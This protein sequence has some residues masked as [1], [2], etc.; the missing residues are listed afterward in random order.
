MNRST[1][2]LFALLIVLGAIV[3]FLIPSSKEREVSDKTPQLTFTVDSASVVRLD[4]L[5]GAKTVTFEN[6]GGRWMITAPGRYLADA[7]SVIQA[8]K[9]LASFRIGSL[10]SSNPEK[11]KLFQV[12]SSGTKITVT[13]RSGKSSSI[14]IGKMGPSFS[15]VYCRAPASRDVYLGEGIDSWAVNKE[16]KEWRDKA[17]MLM[18]SESVKDIS[19]SAGGRQFDF[20]RDSTTWELGTSTVETSVMNPPLATFAN[21]RADDF[22][23]TAVTPQTQPIA[24]TVKGVDRVTLQLFPVTPDSSKYVVRSS[25]SQQL[26]VINKYVAQQIFKPLEGQEVFHKGASAPMAVKKPEP[27]AT[28]PATTASGLNQKPSLPQAGTGEKK[29]TGKTAVAP[30]LSFGKKS[31]VTSQPKSGVTGKSSGINPSQ[32]IITEK[33]RTTAP[34]KIPNTAGAPTKQSAP[35]TNP[36]PMSGKNVDSGAVKTQPTSEPQPSKPPAAGAKR[37][38]SSTGDDEGELTV[39]T[40]KAGETM[41]IIAKKFNCTVEQILKWNLLKSI[42][43]KPGQELYIYVNK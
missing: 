27:M 17:I 30:A 25:S 39:Y 11:Q 4:L 8:I 32:P 19:Y 13:E 1:M 15:E 28:P 38:Q 37:T 14:I 22:V 3:Y 23:D 5:R 10:I 9:G 36:P 24:V 42:T 29:Q 26:F 7:P 43:V 31:G 33:K 2:I 34:S 16:L 18:P 40:V 35:G 41:P 6:V 12:D 20:H 21:L